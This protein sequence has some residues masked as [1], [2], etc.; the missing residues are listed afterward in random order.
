MAQQVAVV[1]GAQ[2]EELEAAVAVGVDRGVERRSVGL[3]EF[4]HVVGDEALGVADLDRLGEPRDVLVADFLVD[5]R[6][7][8]TRGEAWSSSAPRR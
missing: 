5:H 3:D 4:E 2:A 1:H 7:E 8:Q 6:G